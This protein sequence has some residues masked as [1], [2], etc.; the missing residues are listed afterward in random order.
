[1]L[2][3]LVTEGELFFFVINVKDHATEFKFDD[4]YDSCHLLNDNIMCAIEVPIAGESVLVCGYG[5]VDDCCVFD[6]RDSGGRVFLGDC[7]PICV[8]QACFEVVAL[9]SH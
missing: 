3:E 1:M 9:G 8:L 6:V 2:K 4:V 5:D 7:D